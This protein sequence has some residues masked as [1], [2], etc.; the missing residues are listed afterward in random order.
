MVSSDTISCQNSSFLG[1]HV[2]FG[3]RRILFQM[4]RVIDFCDLQGPLGKIKISRIFT[5]WWF[6]IIFLF[7]PH[8]WGDNPIWRSYFSNGLVETTN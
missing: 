2:N 5:S 7:S 1:G 8:T 3:G 6:Q 4:C